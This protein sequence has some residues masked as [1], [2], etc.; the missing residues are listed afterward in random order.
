M[1]VTD[2]IRRPIFTEKA[3]LQGEVSNTYAFEVD[4]SANKVQI[5][6]A[7]EIQFDRKVAEVRVANM[8]GKLRRQGR[9]F[10]FQPDWKKAYVRLAEGEKPLEF[11]EGA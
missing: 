1:R 7:V 5:R 3:T 11:F 9:Y 6:R 10:G 8:H 2:V 4:R